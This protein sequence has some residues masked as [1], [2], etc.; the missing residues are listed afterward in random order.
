[1]TRDEILKNIQSTLDS[2]KSKLDKIMLIKSI[3]EK[4][5]KM[6]DVDYKKLLEPETIDH[7]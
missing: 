1:M 2:D 5:F 4:N 3:I 7:F 6:T